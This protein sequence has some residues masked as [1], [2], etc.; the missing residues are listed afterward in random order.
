MFMDLTNALRQI[1]DNERAR[2]DLP[3]T[4]PLKTAGATLA[5]THFDAEARRLK[6]PLR[7]HRISR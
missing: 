6:R 4:G 7:V 3:V 5:A 2:G 1:Q